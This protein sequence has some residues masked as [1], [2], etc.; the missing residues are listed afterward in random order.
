MK[1]L[2]RSSFALISLALLLPQ[3]FAQSAEHGC[4]A[5][6]NQGSARITTDAGAI[7]L[8]IMRAN[9]LRVDVQP[10]QGHSPRTIV[11]DPALHGE[12]PVAGHVRVLGNAVQINLPG[13][14]AIARCGPEL[15]ITF[16]DAAG[17]KLV[18]Q[19]H[20]LQSAREHRVTF[21]HDASENLYGMSG[22]SMRDTSHGLLRNDGNV[23]TAGQQGE[24]GAPWFFTTRYGVMIDSDDGK[25]N[26]HDQSIE[27]SGISRK[28]SEYFVMAGGP[29]ETIAALASITG[30]PPMPPKWTLGFLNSQWG[31]TED[32][33]MQIVATYRVK[34]IPLDALILDFDW[35]AW[36]EDNYG[37]WRWNS[38]SGPGNVHPDEFPDGESG[39]FA[40]QMRAQGVKLAGILK[41]RILLYKPGSKTELEEAAAYAEGH[42]LWYPGEPKITDYFTGRPGRDLDFSKA[43]TR[44]WYWNHLKPAFHE[45]LVGWWNDEADVTGTADGKAFYF[46]SFQFLNMGRMLYEGQRE[47][48]NLRVWSINRNTYLGAQRYGYAA[49]SG[50]IPTGFQSMEQQ[51]MRMLATLDLGQ[52]HWSMDTGG[53]AGHPGP[54]NYARWI[55]F[56]TFVPIDRVHGDLG[57][58]RQPWVY[59]P[60]A[61]AAA[62]KAIQLRYRLLPYIYSYERAASETGVGIV[63]PLFWKY[64]G[65]PRVANEGTEWM[66]GDAF[67]VS[68]VVKEG[69]TSHDV[70]LP[71]GEW[72]DYFRGKVLPGGQ[73]ISYPVDPA[74]WQDIPLFVHAGSIV[75]TQPEQDYVD[76]RT[77]TE[78]T[79]DIFPGPDSTV[80]TYYDDDG[81]TY[82]YERGG[83]YRQEIRSSTD[84]HATMIELAK[85]TGTYQTA[86]RTYLLRI[87]AMDIK[88]VTCN[89]V[90]VPKD[91]ES[92]ALD[93]P[94]EGHWTLG[95]DRFGPVA[96]IRVR[97]RQAARIELY[98]GRGLRS[99]QGRV[100]HDTRA[101]RGQYQ[102]LSKQ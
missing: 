2:S 38:T 18:E 22:L 6:A 10:D 57:E 55:E 11:L 32:E 91:T 24:G 76:Q 58:K 60:T 71:A 78:I 25:F 16:S 48:S 15:S 65:D 87:H 36:G 96:I 53:F 77:A 90:Q 86:L 40:A 94:R 42:G 59:G 95:K 74:T 13:L 93:I 66:F 79:L 46:D 70:Y 67:L 51:R 45:G 28:D 62:T 30:R 56:A 82:D 50:D 92:S 63:R 52:P 102:S 101:I 54:E 49:W 19:V 12:V 39:G 69:E 80:F 83:Y 4:A 73:T 17:H 37:E 100:A 64:P 97:G 75:A 31:A 88:A 47:D 3:L 35:K 14:V 72:Y 1:Y 61:E 84:A 99:E 98:G 29:M 33:L 7:D 5:T 68:P 81:T 89:G 8:E 27:L 21:L 20:P 44:T 85:P 23:V 41:P 26:T 9:V 43:E 34:H